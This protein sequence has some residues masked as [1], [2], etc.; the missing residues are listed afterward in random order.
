MAPVKSSAITAVGYDPEALTMRIQFSS[1]RVH[2]YPGTAPGQHKAL[3]KAASIGGHFNRRF[4]G[5]EHV[6]VE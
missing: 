4:R 3:L 6:R 2:D 5:R 1:G